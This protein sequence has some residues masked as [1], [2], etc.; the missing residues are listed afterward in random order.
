[1]LELPVSF[2]E[3]NKEPQTLP[4]NHS[5]PTFWNSFELTQQRNTLSGTGA[6][7]KSE[8]RVELISWPKP[9]SA[10]YELSFWVY[11]EP[12][13]NGMPETEVQYMYNGE[14]VHQDRIN[15]KIITD[16]YKDWLKVTI[17][18]KAEQ[19][20]QEVLVFLHGDQFWIDDLMV[21][22]QNQDV[23]VSLDKTIKKNNFTISE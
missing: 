11:I 2:F 6:F 19:P 21:R 9:D 8:G 1:L 15:T 3:N 16:I 4:E 12:T 14:S 13:V 18:L 20:W 10:E 22:K 17:D 7:Y 23:Y 5:K